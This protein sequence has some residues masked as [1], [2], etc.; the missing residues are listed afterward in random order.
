MDNF[1]FFVR[2]GLFHVLDWNAYDHVLFLIALAVVYDFNNW[3]KVFWLISL[4]TLGHTV[5][6]FLAAYQVVNF[7]SDLIE[8][9]IPVTIIVTA[10]FNIWFAKGTAK[11]GRTNTNLFFALFFGLI[12]GFGFSG[13][14][15]ILIGSSESKLLPLLEF[16]LG[17][18]LAQILVVIVILL[19]GYLFQSLFRFSKRD[20]VLVVS[21]IVIG[22][23]L[24]I[25]RD[26][27]FW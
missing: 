22:I 11:T 14:F 10:L 1:L 5:T 15:R 20:W 7:S 9:L 16:A 18:E 26:S 17:I 4:F 13:Y 3:K 12:H 25:L 6:L 23:V 24:P 2:E 19:L 21:A 27:I 8:F